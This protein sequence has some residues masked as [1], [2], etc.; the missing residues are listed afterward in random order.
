MCGNCPDF[1]DMCTQGACH[2]PQGGRYS[3]YAKFYFGDTF[4]EHL[5]ERYGTDDASLY[6]HVYREHDPYDYLDEDETPPEFV[7]TCEDDCIMNGWY[8]LEEIERVSRK[9]FPSDGPE[10]L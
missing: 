10:R 8:T 9:V 2:T 4:C 6:Y 7:R 3:K 5:A 1:V